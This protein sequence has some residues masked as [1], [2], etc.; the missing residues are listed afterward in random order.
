MVY[1]YVIKLDDEIICAVSS[2]ERANSIIQN[3][4]FSRGKP[5]IEKIILDDLSKLFN[6]NK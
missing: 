1:I 4:F 5:I 6:Y 3:L 2:Y